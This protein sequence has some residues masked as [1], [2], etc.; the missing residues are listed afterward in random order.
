MYD[1]SSGTRVSTVTDVL[2]AIV[3]AKKQGRRVVVGIVGPPA[4][5]KS[6][7]ARDLA[8]AMTSHGTPTEVLQMDGFHLANAQLAEAGLAQEKGSPRTFDTAGLVAILRRVHRSDDANPIF[9]PQYDRTVHEPIAARGRIDAS[10]EVVLVEGNYLL[11]DEPGWLDVGH[12][13][14]LS[15]YLDCSAALRQ[16]RLVERQ[17]RGGR[18]VDDASEW[19]RTVDEPNALVIEGTRYRADFVSDSTAFDDEIADAL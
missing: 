5:G 4:S 16:R 6:Y 2:R 12:L 8:R 17:V 11:L 19:V 13:L 15:W 7:A 3:T 1:E 10:T 18:S 14:T 9:T